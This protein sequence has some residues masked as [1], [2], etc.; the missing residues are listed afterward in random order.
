M[1]FELWT[2]L[3]CMREQGISW[4]EIPLGNTHLLIEMQAMFSSMQAHSLEDYLA[5]CGGHAYKDV[6]EARE[7]CEKHY[8][9][10]SLRWSLMTAGLY[11][12]FIVFIAVHWLLWVAEPIQALE[13]QW[14]G[15]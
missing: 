13:R 15:L 11:Y 9:A 8:Y 2:V 1:P 6:D 7:D 3:G 4:Q 10:Q 14:M 12:G 5:T